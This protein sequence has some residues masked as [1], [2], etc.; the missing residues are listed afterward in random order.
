M[1][2]RVFT[3]GEIM[4]RIFPSLRG[5]R[6]FQAEHYKIIPGGSAS[7]V[8]AT[9]S[10]LGNRVSFITKL[11]EGFGKDMIYRYLHSHSVDPSFIVV[12]KGRLGVYWTEN[13]VGEIPY[14]VFYDRENTAFQKLNIDELNIRKINSLGRWFHFSGITPALSRKSFKNLLFLLERLDPK[15]Y[16]SCDLNYRAKLWNWVSERSRFKTINTCMTKIL[17][18]I[19]LLVSN[20]SDLHY[21]LG[22]PKFTG[23]NFKE[24]K[25]VAE[26]LFRRF[27]RLKYIAIS[28]RK[29]YTATENDWSGILYVRKNPSKARC[30]LYTTNT[31]ALKNI[32]DRLGTGDCF[33]AGIIHGILNNYKPNK[34]INFAVSLSTY[35]H[36]MVGDVGSF[37]LRDVITL[38]NNQ[39]E[40]KIKR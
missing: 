27:Q 36:Y 23:K 37:T 31:H 15:L 28:V 39:R 29:I 9:L 3:F 4:L 5:E 17:G 26:D 32:V 19:H 40:L 16:I 35:K 1:G 25:D 6:L 13:G 24:Y 30:D 33:A 14:E 34:T 12:G 8:A 2:K 38:S 11:P 21:M 10:Q 22:Y 18:H 7:N 20:E